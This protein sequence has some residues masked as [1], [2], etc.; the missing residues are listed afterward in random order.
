MIDLDRKQEFLMELK[1]FVSTL[2]EKISQ[3]DE[4]A[5][6]IIKG[7]DTLNIDLQNRYLGLVKDREFMGYNLPENVIITF[8]VD[9]KEGLKKISSELYHF[10]VVAF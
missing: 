2:S 8:S 10:C 7:I 1:K 4:F 6:F 3:N 9:N 5:Y